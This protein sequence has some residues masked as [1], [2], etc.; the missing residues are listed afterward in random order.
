MKTILWIGLLIIVFLAAF[1][2][3]YLFGDN[4][5]QE[6]FSTYTYVGTLDTYEFMI[7]PQGDHF[8]NWSITYKRNDFVHEKKNYQTPYPYGPM[9]LLEIPIEDFRKEFQNTEMVYITR[10][11]NLDEKTQSE[12]VVSL[13][14]LDRLVE[15]FKGNDNTWLAVIEEND[16]SR[17]LHLPL[18]TCEDAN[19]ERMVIWLKEGSEN[20]VSVHGDYCVIGEFA[21]GEDP[22]KVATKIAYH[23][24]G[25]M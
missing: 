3:D 13:L 25:V 7:N 5:E 6:D 1:G 2:S 11:I 4:T 22:N 18:M 16:K 9:K 19:S 8:L 15:K 17:E 10:D 21:E 23:I 20:K 14:S 24:V 12:I